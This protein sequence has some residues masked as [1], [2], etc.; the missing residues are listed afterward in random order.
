MHSG[1][2]SVSCWQH[3]FFH[4]RNNSEVHLRYES[5]TNL[6]QSF[7]FIVQDNT[8]G[9]SHCVCHDSKEQLLR[10]INLLDRDVLGS[11]HGS[12]G[13]LQ[14]GSCNH[15]SHYQLQAEE[16]LDV[17]FSWLHPWPLMSACLKVWKKSSKG[18]GAFR[19]G[20]I[21][22]WSSG[23]PLDEGNHCVHFQHHTQKH[24]NSH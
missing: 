11:D 7:S 23:T 15:F 20:E 18:T 3:Y 16:G 4:Y 10:L 19:L 9:A 21:L 14:Q 5:A 1:A 2:L 17:A 13:N 22:L 12:S 6:P 8:E 24:G